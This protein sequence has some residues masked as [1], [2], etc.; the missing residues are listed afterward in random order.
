MLYAQRHATLQSVHHISNGAQ[1]RCVLSQHCVVHTK[2]TAADAPANCTPELC[3]QRRDVEDVIR[4]ALQVLATL[5]QL[6]EARAALRTRASGAGCT[7]GEKRRRYALTAVLAVFVFDAVLEGGEPRCEA[8]EPL[9]CG[10]QC[11]VRHGD[12]TRATWYRA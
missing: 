11:E 4:H 12:I 8:V 2:W 9:A 5:P 6:L 10:K 3:Q 1:R 7:S